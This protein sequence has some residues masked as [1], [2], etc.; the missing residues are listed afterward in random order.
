VPQVRRDGC[1]RGHAVPAKTGS[2]WPW[3]RC[4][5]GPVHAPPLCGAPTRRLSRPRRPSAHLSF[6][7]PSSVPSLLHTSSEALAHDLFAYDSCTKRHPRGRITSSIGHLRS[8]S[9]RNSESCRPL[10]VGMKATAIAAGPAGLSLLVLLLPVVLAC[11][12]EPHRFGKREEGSGSDLNR[13]DGGAAAAI[14]AY[15]CDPSTCK[16]PSCRCVRAAHVASPSEVL[17]M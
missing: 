8:T 1:D 12:P 4:G 5:S 13:N 10:P 11:A 6:S 2:A 9:T 16:L 17:T 15:D 7:P 3:A 14:A